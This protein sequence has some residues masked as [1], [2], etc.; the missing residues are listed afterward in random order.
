MSRKCYKYTRGV[1][2][3]LRR[4]ILKR[5]A[6][7]A[8]KQHIKIICIYPIDRVEDFKPEHSKWIDENFW[9]LF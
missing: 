6:K 1:G 4:L 3:W 2:C 7:G 8:I 5:K 9:E